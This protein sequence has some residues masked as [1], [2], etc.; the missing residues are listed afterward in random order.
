MP[1]HHYNDNDSSVLLRI[2]IGVMKTVLIILTFSA[3]QIVTRKKI[4]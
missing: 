4:L 3:V 1:T 2:Y